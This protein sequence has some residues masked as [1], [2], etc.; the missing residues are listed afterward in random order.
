MGRVQLVVALSPLLLGSML[1][2]QAPAPQNGGFSVPSAQSPGLGPGRFPG[3]PD[4]QS[5]PVREYSR[6]R[7]REAERQRRIVDDANRLMKLTAQYRGDVERHGTVT[8]DDEK[9]LLQI[10]KLAREVKDRMRGM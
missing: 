1:C 7:A 4:L 2:G 10:E 5:D 3:D 8:A 9:L 6:Q